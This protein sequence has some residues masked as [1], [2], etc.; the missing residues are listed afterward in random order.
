MCIILN[1][2]D[3]VQR[4]QET[5]PDNDK[6]ISGSPPKI[7][8]CARPDKPKARDRARGQRAGKRAE[9]PSSETIEDPYGNNGVTDAVIHHVDDPAQI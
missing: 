1:G 5:E 4:T 2:W 7:K 6:P 8:L 3:H 9:P